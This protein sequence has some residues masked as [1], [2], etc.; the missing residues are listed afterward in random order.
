MRPALLC[1][2]MQR[3][4]TSG[5]GQRM[6]SPRPM[7]RISSSFSTRNWKTRTTT[8]TSLG[9]GTTHPQKRRKT[10]SQLRRTQR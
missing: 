8:M 5:L 10:M 7:E 2:R 9:M 1:T 6:M 3:S 4:G